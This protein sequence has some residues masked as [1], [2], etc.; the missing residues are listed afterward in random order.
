M[1]T[2]QSSHTVFLG[3]GSNVGDRHANLMDAIAGLRRYIR[4]LKISSIHQTKP[5]GHLDQDTFLNAVVQGTTAM[6]PHEL[7]A[8]NQNLEKEIGRIKRFRN[9]PREIDIDILFYDDLIMEP[10]NSSNSHVQAQAKLQ[11][12]HPRITER[13]FVLEPLVELAPY[14]IHPVKNRMTH[15]LLTD[16]RLPSKVRTKIVGILNLSPE[17]FAGEFCTDI[18]A[19]VA[20]AVSMVKEG[21]DIIDI[22][23]QSTRPGSVRLSLDEELRRLQGAISTIKKVLPDMPISIDATRP[24]CVRLALDEG[25]DMVNDISG[26]R[27]NEIESNT[28]HIVD[29]VTKHPRGRD[30]QYILTH[31]QGSFDELHK[32]YSYENIIKD[33]KEYFIQ[34]IKELTEK[35]LS[36]DQIILDPGIGFSKSGE[37]NMEILRRLHKLHEIGLPLYIGISRKKFIGTLIKDINPEAERDPKERDIGTTIL[38]AHCFRSGV[39][40]IRTHNISQA[41]QCLEIF[42]TLGSRTRHE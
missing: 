31:S 40:Y 10:V 42:K 7:L 5:E 14:Y 28:E 11:I 29:M 20:R 15:E 18:D 38:H 24:E 30:I 1:K 6:S 41:K 17:S 8:A 22:G 34:V 19:T 27:M 39:A 9:G 2:D 35:G 37:Q 4:D 13:I 16:L 23:A 3:L 21:A 26:G 33:L 12:P 25:V 32:K 36:R